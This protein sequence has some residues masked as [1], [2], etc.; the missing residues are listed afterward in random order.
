MFTVTKDRGMT[1]ANP[2]A[3]RKDAEKVSIYQPN[4]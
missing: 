3:V 2:T 4:S 1:A